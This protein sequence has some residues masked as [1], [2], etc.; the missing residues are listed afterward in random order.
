GE[1]VPHTTTGGSPPH[2]KNTYHAAFSRFKSQGTWE[3]KA[4]DSARRDTGT[5]NSWTLTFQ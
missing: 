3:L 4:V 1:V 2:I 5:I